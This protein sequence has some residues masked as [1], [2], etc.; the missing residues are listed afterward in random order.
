MVLPSS[1]GLTGFIASFLS[2]LPSFLAQGW[3]HSTNFHLFTS[4]FSSHR[5]QRKNSIDVNY[6]E[7]GGREDWVGKGGGRRLK[8]CNDWLTVR[9]DTSTH[10]AWYYN[11]TL[12]VQLLAKRSRVCVCLLSCLCIIEFDI[13]ESVT[14][15]AHSILCV[16]VFVFGLTSKGLRA[17]WKIQSSGKE[18]RAEMRLKTKLMVKTNWCW[19]C[20]VCVCSLLISNYCFH[21]ARTQ[22]HTHT[23]NDRMISK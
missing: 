12:F 21:S 10:P 22:T 16:C 9:M 1:T 6:P 8:S 19:R 7:E 2:F 23:P 14:L 20:V 13:E 18:E 4:L 3:T 15:S 5:V 17:N 11:L